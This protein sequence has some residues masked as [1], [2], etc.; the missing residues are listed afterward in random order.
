MCRVRSSNYSF[1]MYF[2]GFMMR[3][4]TKTYTTTKWVPLE[5]GIA[6]GCAIPPSLFELVMQLLLNAVGSNV[7]EAHLGKGLYNVR[8]FVEG[9]NG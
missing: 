8:N 6:M 1:Q 2:D 4:S 3:F 5:V 9:V 7:P